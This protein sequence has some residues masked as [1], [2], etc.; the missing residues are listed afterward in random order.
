MIASFCTR[1]RTRSASLAALSALCTWSCAEPNLPTLERGPPRVVASI[2]PLGNLTALVAGTDLTVDV[3]VPPRADPSTFEPS[4]R[5]L[6]ELVGARAFILV[7][8]GLDDWSQTVLT[9]TGDIPRVVL[10]DGLTLLER[11]EGESADPH[12]WLD[13]VL[14]R[15]SWLP[16]IVATLVAARPDAQETLEARGRVVADSLTTLDAWMSARLAPVRGR[17][18]VATHSAWSYLAARHGISELGAVYPSPGQE[19][20][21]RALAA[22]VQQARAAGVRAVFTE[23][24]LGETGAKALAS[25]LSVPVYVLDPLGGPG[26]DGRE[27]YLEMMRFNTEQM[28]RALDGDR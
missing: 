25:E 22:L 27:T 10:N 14:V 21:P 7:G 19:P 9:G 2:F 24:Q 26:L 4:P 23:P 15:D 17:A 1:G 11:G 18:F 12:V 3:M 8:G 20:S 13:P 16:R 6:R 5:R 28:A